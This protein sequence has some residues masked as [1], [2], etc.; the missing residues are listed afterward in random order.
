MPEIL[1]TEDLGL[2]AHFPGHMICNISFLR[3]PVM[4]RI[5]SFHL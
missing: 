3:T 5:F 4:V 1:S 2:L